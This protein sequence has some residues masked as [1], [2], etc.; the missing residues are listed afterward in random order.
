MPADGRLVRYDT[1]STFTSKCAWSVFDASVLSGGSGVGA[2]YDGRFLYAM[3]SRTALRFDTK[4]PGWMPACVPKGG[5][6][7]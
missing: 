5:S 4:S 6:F 7:L 2:V 1:L 3:P